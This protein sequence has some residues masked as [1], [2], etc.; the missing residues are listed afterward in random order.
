MKNIRLVFKNSKNHHD[1]DFKLI[2]SPISMKWFKKLQHLHRLPLSDSHSVYQ[3]WPDTNRY[4]IKSLHEE[5]CR[6][7][8]IEFEILDYSRQGNL[9]L[10]HELYEQHHDLAV[11]IHPDILY[12]FHRAIHETQNLNLK[13]QYDNLE[14]GWGTLEGPL[15]Q[16]INMNIY[17]SDILKHGNLYLKWSELGKL[18][19]QYFSDGEPN[20]QTRFNALAKPNQTLRAK[21][22]LQLSENKFQFTNEFNDWFEKYKTGW[23]S[24]HGIDDW[25]AI[26]EISGVHV[27]EPLQDIDLEKFISKYPYFEK[28]ELP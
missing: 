11:D 13:I 4:E 26:D 9:N 20:N 3:P 24:H 17:Y 22:S 18:P 2:E 19:F 28:I 25:R 15:E 1:L 16:K 23:L 7:V 21:F 8:K 14:F 27:A 5:F 10:L 12:K 6:A